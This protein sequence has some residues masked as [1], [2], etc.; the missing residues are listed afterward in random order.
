MPTY[1]TISLKHVCDASRV[2]AYVTELGKHD[3]RAVLAYVDQHVPSPNEAVIAEYLKALTKANVFPQYIAQDL[4]V[5]KHARLS[6]LPSSVSLYNKAAAHRG[7][8][9]IIFF[10][11]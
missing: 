2:H 10:L 1:P 8:T 7:M 3:P 11:P 6:V 5:S 4:T 9:V